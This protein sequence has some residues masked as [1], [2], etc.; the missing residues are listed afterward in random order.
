MRSVFIHAITVKET[1]WLDANKATCAYWPIS[2]QICAWNTYVQT[3]HRLYAHPPRA[4]FAAS[5]WTLRLLRAI[6]VIYFA[7]CDGINVVAATL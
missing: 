3:R 6:N 1:Q 7:F 2:V 4:H 5:K